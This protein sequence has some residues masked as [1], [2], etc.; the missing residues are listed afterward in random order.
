M[1]GGEAAGGH[2][3]RER[4][5][6]RSSVCSCAAVSVQLQQ[7]RAAAAAAAHVGPRQRLRRLQERGRLCRRR[8]MER[9]G[10]TGRSGERHGEGPWRAGRQRCKQERAP[11]RTPA[12]RPLRPPQPAPANSWAPA[13][14]ISGSLHT[15]LHHGREGAGGRR[16]RVQAGGGE[17]GCTAWAHCREPALEVLLAGRGQ[18]RQ[19]QHL[20]GPSS[21]LSRCPTASANR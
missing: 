5:V 20:M 10:G 1:E 16:K 13:S 17:G 12:C 15:R 19:R 8:G 14:T 21:R 4:T 3:R 2:S 7:H 18:Q 6:Q 9:E 11:T